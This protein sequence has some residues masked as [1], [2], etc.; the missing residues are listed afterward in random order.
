MAAVRR[1]SWHESISEALRQ[2]AFE[3]E[4]L[5]WTAAA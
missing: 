4:G 5:E 3:D 2:A 1:T